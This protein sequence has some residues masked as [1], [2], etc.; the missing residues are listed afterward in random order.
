MTLGG[1]RCSAESLGR[2]ESL[3]ATASLVAAWILIEQP[4]AWGPEALTESKFPY[5]VAD[6]LQRRAGRIRILLIRR[7]ESSGSLVLFKAN[8]G[9]EGGP[10]VLVAEGFTD[11]AD[12]LGIDFEALTQG[13]PG[14]GSEV[15]DPMY[16]VCTH[17]RH[18]ICCADRGRPLYRA[19]SEIRPDQTW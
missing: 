3:H 5:E 1:P 9:V 14:S 2:A 17:G 16:L 12:L 19:M 11:P 15:P 4:G 7:R 6:Q 18:D 10:P 13:D 8:S